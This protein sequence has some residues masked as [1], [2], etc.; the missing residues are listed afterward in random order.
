MIGRVY[1][2]ITA[3][4]LI[5]EGDHVTVA[6]SGGADS[7]FLLTVLG[8]L[9]ERI[10]FGMSAFH[11]NHCI[12]GEESDR[13][14]S[15][16]R[17][18][19]VK[20]GIPFSSVRV[21]VPAY[22]RETGMSCEEA[23]RKLRYDALEQSAGGGLIATAHNMCDNAETVLFNL[24]RG[25]G[26]KGMC[27]I[28]Y[29]RGNIIRPILD[30]Q[31]SEIEAFL[32]Q[33]GIGYVTDSTNLTDDYSRNRLRHNVIP[34][35]TR[36]NPAFIRSAARLSSSARADEEYFADI[37]EALSPE[38]VPMQPAAIR[39]RY[40][41]RML[42]IHGIP[43]SYDR[44]CGMD[45]LMEHRKSTLY[46]LSGDTFAVFSKGVL[47]I[48]TASELPDFECRIDTSGCEIITP[49]DKTVM[50][51]RSY[52]E[53]SKFHKKLTYTA[54]NCDK[55]QGV[56]V[57]RN[58]R[59]GDRIQL[60]GRDFTTRLKKLYNSIGLSRFRRSAALV[61][62]DEAGLVWSEYGGVSERA[63][64]VPGGDLIYISV[65]GNTDR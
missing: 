23:A 19:C 44:I 21:D 14:E 50:I 28:P 36:I 20:A 53:N 42:D 51:C 13:D 54:L 24:T 56:A 27:G 22:V 40:I 38:E 26:I 45:E 55:I 39:R 6:L 10:G 5:S 1:D 37:V 46:E 17:D 43:V 57:L 47:S 30:I 48:E 64:A 9:R 59:D 63:K 18:M 12:R 58:K 32:A 65:Y 62:E 25:T 29:R 34:E 2:T 11:V 3:H 4:K 52:D 60:A 33:R 15:F 41:S 31:R 61:I 8:E 7:V 35:L 16:C 49:Y